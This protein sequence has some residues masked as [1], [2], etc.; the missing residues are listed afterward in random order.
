[1]DHII[2]ESDN[3]RNKLLDIFCVDNIIE[4]ND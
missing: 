3:T 2:D 4:A 1:M